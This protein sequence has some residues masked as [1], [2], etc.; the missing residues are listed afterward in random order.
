MRKTLI[1]VFVDDVRLVQNEVALDEDRYRVVRIHHS[2]IFGLVIEINVDDLKVH[3][4][5]MQDDTALV[6]EWVGGA[7]IKRHHRAWFPSFLRCILCC[8]RRL[9]M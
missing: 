6:A 8:V 5:F 4:L 2:K 1:N 7:G 3:A 9:M